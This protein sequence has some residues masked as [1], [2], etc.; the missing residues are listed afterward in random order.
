MTHFDAILDVIFGLSEQELYGSSPLF[1]LL[2]LPPSS[3]PLPSPPFFSFFS[4]GAA[5]RLQIFSFSL[6]Q[7]GLTQAGHRPRAGATPCFQWS[8]HDL[9]LDNGSGR[10]A[11]QGFGRGHAGGVVCGLMTAAK[12]P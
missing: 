11:Q 3:S 4:F 6:G 12:F 9:L 2:P 1:F 5:A 8:T 10:L 7:G